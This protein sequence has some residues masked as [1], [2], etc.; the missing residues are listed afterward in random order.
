MHMAK[1]SGSFGA[2]LVLIASC[3]GKEGMQVQVSPE[4]MQVS[5]HEPV[6]ANITVRNNT[7]AS[8]T[9]DLGTDF[10]TQYR[11]AVTPPNG[12][13]VNISTQVPGHHGPKWRTDHRRR[14][15]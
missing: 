6:I 5:L 3:A 15:L 14:K 12:Q 9:V 7:Q 13:T 4:S 2:L 11:L 8:A 10:K 1:T